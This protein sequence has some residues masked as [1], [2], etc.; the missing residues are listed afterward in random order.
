MGRGGGG[1]VVS[2]LAFYSSNLSLNPAGY[3]FSVLY[4]EK[5]KI[6]EKRLGLAQLKE[7]VK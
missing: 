2:I 3:Q 7:I 1:T 5:T 6:N 4:N